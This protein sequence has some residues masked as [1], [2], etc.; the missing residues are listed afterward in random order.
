METIRMI[1]SDKLMLF[2]SLAVSCKSAYLL[3]EYHVLYL[4]TLINIYIYKMYVP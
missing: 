1:N 3:Y 4:L 2:V